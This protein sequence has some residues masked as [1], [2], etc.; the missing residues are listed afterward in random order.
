M[1]GSVAA[2]TPRCTGTDV[3]MILI[4][5]ANSESCT[6]SNLASSSHLCVCH[7]GRDPRIDGDSEETSATL[8][9]W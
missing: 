2:V 8:D 4:P 6:P 1:R 3:P 5:A 7:G 9:T